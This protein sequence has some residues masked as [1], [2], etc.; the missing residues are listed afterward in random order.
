MATQ[1]QVESQVRKEEEARRKKMQAEI[2]ITRK[3][4]VERLK[5]AQEANQRELARKEREA[6]DGTL[7]KDKL[8]HTLTILM[9]LN[10]A[11]SN[12]SGN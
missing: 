4:G 3:A 11:S 1:R 9:V 5:K 6:A 10:R 12:A 8:R 7:S 2:E